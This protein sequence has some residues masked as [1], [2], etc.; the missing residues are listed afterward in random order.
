MFTSG[1][2]HV[3]VQ[4]LFSV[5]DFGTHCGDPSLGHAKMTYPIS[6]Y[7]LWRGFGQDG[8]QVITRSGG[9]VGTRRYKVFSI[10]LCL[11][12]N[13]YIPCSTKEVK[14]E[15][16]CCLFSPRDLFES[17]KVVHFNE[18]QLMFSCKCSGHFRPFN[19]F[20]YSSPRQM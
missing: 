3:L 17:C 11:L 19:R 2:T 4:P 12:G 13:S 20:Y 5:L 14:K 15:D 10:C 9:G 16:S 6:S 7:A 18:L 1:P 8:G